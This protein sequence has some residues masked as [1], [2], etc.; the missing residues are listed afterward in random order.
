MCVCTDRG[1]IWKLNS[2]G[3]AKR[4]GIMINFSVSR[5][6][7]MSMPMCACENKK[8]SPQLG[9]PVY[10]HMQSISH[11]HKMAVISVGF[12]YLLWKSG[13]LGEWL[14]ERRRGRVRFFGSQPLPGSV[15]NWTKGGN[16]GKRLP[17]TQYW[18]KR[19][20]QNC[21]FFFSSFAWPSKSMRAE[22]KKQRN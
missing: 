18:Q 21:F 16:S 14:E 4:K 22:D 3:I 10:P 12:Y 17:L 15:K 2:S 1:E 11:S 8:Q 5:P 6:G 13:R 7:S 19:K 20:R 9:I